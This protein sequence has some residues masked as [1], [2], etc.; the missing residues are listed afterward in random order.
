MRLFASV[1]PGRLRELSFAAL[2]TPEIPGFITEESV[3]VNQQNR[4]LLEFGH[5]LGTGS[6]RPCLDLTLLVDITQTLI[7]LFV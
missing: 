1:T 7:R 6:G 5:A 2:L 3:L 4:W